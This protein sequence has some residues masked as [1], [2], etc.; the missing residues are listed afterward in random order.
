MGKDRTDSE[1]RLSRRTLLGA[2][3]A[4]AAGLAFDSLAAKAASQ[5]SKEDVINGE[6]GQSAT[7]PIGPANAA[8]SQQNPDSVMPPPTDHGDVPAFKYPFAFSHKRTQE[9]GWARQVTVEDFPISK[10]IAGVNMRLGSGGIRE[11]HWHKAAEWAFMLYGSARITAIDTG[12]QSFVDDVHEGDIWNFPSGIPHSIQG[13]APDGCEFLLV[14]DDGAFSEYNTTSLTDLLAHTPPGPLA[15]SFGIPREAL[16]SI[17]GYERYIFQGKLPGPLEADQRAATGRMGRSRPFDFRLTQMEA[18]KRTRG[19]EVRVVDSKN[20]PASTTIAAALVTVHPGGIRELHWHPN[21][22]EWQYY[23]RGNARMTVFAAGGRA[24][25][26]DFQR[27]D[28]GYIEKTLPHYIENTGT[29]DLS[30]LEMFRSDHYED[31]SLSNWLSHTPSQLVMQHLGF[32]K[33]TLNA[34]PKDEVAIMPL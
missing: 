15:K 11:L 14:F 19:G 32:D 21:A 7:N 5:D 3:P 2:L 4:T 28:V 12:G 10:S 9:G 17:P 1:H 27:G 8:L 16:S 25:T 29:T 34:I 18:S 33:A 20:F 23:I 13:L 26:M 31:I 6:H 24:R 30:F 22:D